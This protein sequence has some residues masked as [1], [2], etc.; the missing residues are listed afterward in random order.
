MYSG[1]VQ[2]CVMS[3][4]IGFES[5]VSSNRVRAVRA[6]RIPAA[7]IEGEHLFFA[8]DDGKHM[9]PERGGSAG[10]PFATSGG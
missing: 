9:P 7:P 5:R 4:Y 1:V 6:R 10:R 8:S 2:R 3:P